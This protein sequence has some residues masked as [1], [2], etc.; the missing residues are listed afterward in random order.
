[1]RMRL[2]ALLIVALGFLALPAR[3]DLPEVVKRYVDD[4]TLIVG[5]MDAAEL[6]SEAILAFMGELMREAP[7]AERERMLEGMGEGLSGL[8]ERLA[9]LR[10]RGVNSYWFVMGAESFVQDEPALLIVPVADDEQAK[11]VTDLMS[12]TREEHRRV[13]GAVIM[14]SRSRL[15]AAN[16]I[17][18]VERPKLEQLI[19]IGR[20][21]PAFQVAF[22][23]TPFVRM[24]AEL[25]LGQLIAQSPRIPAIAVELVGK[26]E[27]MSF[28]A[29]LP[30]QARVA[31]TMEFPDQ[32]TAELARQVVQ[33]Q[34][35]QLDEDL[36]RAQLE[37]ERVQQLLAAFAPEAQNKR[38]MMELTNEELRGV[39]G[40]IWIITMLQGR[41]GGNRVRA[42]G[43]LRKLAQGILLWTY[44]HGDGR[45]PP[46]LAAVEQV[47]TNPEADGITWQQVRRN[48]RFRA[49]DAFAYV[50]PA[51]RL[52]EIKEPDITVIA[53][54]KPPA[55]GI[56]EGLNVAF[57]DGRVEWLSAADFEEL[58]AAQGFEIQRLPRN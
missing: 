8:E 31:L 12:E 5:R 16:K 18:P 23:P 54:E 34:V 30:P 11:L 29:S 56:R 40:P 33:H 35:E 57:A 45:L 55:D 36:G 26:L 28:S 21:A 17:V 51:D 49:D 47:F 48:P 42:G 43:N 41:E 6:S 22:E 37:P 4:T 10:E 58:A 53:Y 1:M 38:V 24:A 44:E 52:E 32:E 25:G 14:S 15:E 9:P 27:A 46:E 7:E 39:V 19:S 50:R 20:S 2:I 3:A 13:E